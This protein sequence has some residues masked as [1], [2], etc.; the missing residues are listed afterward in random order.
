[1]EYVHFIINFIGEWYWVPLLFLYVGVIST[2]IIENGNPTKT[3][4]WV[5]VIVFLP[6]IGIILYYLFGQ[7]FSKVKRIKK[8]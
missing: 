5:L 8:G 7:K 3:L 4:S 6:V 2:L 1:M